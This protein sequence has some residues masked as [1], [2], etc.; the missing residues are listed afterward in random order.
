M[1]GPVEKVLLIL[2]LKV[3]FDSNTFVLLTFECKTICNRLVVH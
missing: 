1:G 2:I 3:Q